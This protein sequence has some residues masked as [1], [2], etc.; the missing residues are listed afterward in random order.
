MAFAIYSPLGIII[1]Q[2]TIVGHVKISWGCSAPPTP[3]RLSA[4]LGRGGCRRSPLNLPL[5]EIKTGG[6]AAVDEPV[7]N[8]SPTHPEPVP[9]RSRTRSEL[10]PVPG[11][12]PSRM[13]T[14]MCEKPFQCAFYSQS[15][16]FDVAIA[17]EK[18][19]AEKMQAIPAKRYAPWQ[20][21]R[22]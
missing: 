18:V 17:I 4:P 8:L 11:L 12:Y 9:N 7:P 5:V 1:P 22:L 14:I 3:P 15:I 13:R 6:R 16:D 2:E 20:L 19:C 21:C 10:V